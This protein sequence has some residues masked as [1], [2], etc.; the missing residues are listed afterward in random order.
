MMNRTGSAAVVMLASLTAF[1]L[2][3][4]EPDVVLTGTLSGADHETY[5]RL[6]FEVPADVDRVTIRFDYDRAASTTVDLGLEDSQR[7]RGWSGG[8]KSTFVVSEAA[9]TPSYLPGPLPAGRWHLVLGVPNIRQGVTA[10]YRAEIAFA[11]G[12]E[13]FSSS[14][15]DQPLRDEPG[16]YRGDL[17]AHSGHSDGACES[18]TGRRVPCPVHRTLEAA[19]QRGLHFVALAEH[20]ARSHYQSLLEL[21]PAFDD[22]VLL[23]AREITTFHGHFN[24]FGTTAPIDFHAEAVHD[25]EAVL[26]NVTQAGGLVSINHPAL[27]SGE[28][29]MGCG[30]RADT[31]WRHVTAVEVVNG[32]VLAAT[33]GD[34]DGPLSGIPFWE[35]LLDRGL[36]A[37]AVAGSDNHDPGANGTTPGA[38]GRPATVIAAAELSESALL[39]GLASGRVF[40]DVDGSPDRVIDLAARSSSGTAVMGGTLEARAGE[41]LVITVTVNNLPDATVRLVRN[42][43]ASIPPAAEPVMLQDGQRWSLRLAGEDRPG[44]VRAEALDGSGRL[45]LLSNPIFLNH[46]G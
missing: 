36:R 39:A 2:A 7:F 33:G 9:A 22:M 44:W 29:C 43:E 12:V 13:A 16:W 6:P 3:F 23:A 5:R 38:I 24:V 4:G 34:A 28:A 17:H 31:G 8:N 19:A 41:E 32:A 20:N 46:S 18:R 42:G 30:W 27:P 40:V 37:A 15:A 1:S 14:F 25:M 10:G 21:Q 35:R 45:V 11:R 26:A